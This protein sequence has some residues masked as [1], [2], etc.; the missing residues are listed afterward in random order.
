MTIIGLLILVLGIVVVG[1][2]AYWIITKFLPPPAHMIALA[3]V[4]VLL[5]LVLLYTF[6]PGAV[7]TRVW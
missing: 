7:N 3:I 2:L 1:T 4:G 6:F 5:L